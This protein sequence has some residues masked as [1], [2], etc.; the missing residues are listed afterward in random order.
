MC[1]SNLASAA[2]LINSCSAYSSVALCDRKRSF[3]Q[4]F[5]KAYKYDAR[6][7]CGYR[8]AN[9]EAGCYSELFVPGVSLGMGVT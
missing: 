5:L 3:L 6:L 7:V 1:L 2:C 8:T 4:S 9:S